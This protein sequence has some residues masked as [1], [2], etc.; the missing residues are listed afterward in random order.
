MN[1]KGINSSSLI[2]LIKTRT[3]DL[4]GWN[5]YTHREPC[6]LGGSSNPL[7]FDRTQREEPY[8]YRSSVPGDKLY[9]PLPSSREKPL[10]FCMRFWTHTDTHTRTHTP[11]CLTIWAMNDSQ[12]FRINYSYKPKT[13]HFANCPGR[14]GEEGKE[15]DWRKRNLSQSD[16]WQY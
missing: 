12:S 8:A 4:E 2:S 1:L 13:K 7:T 16:N 14:R 11:C 3:H 6:C 10:T 15:T 5:A 9:Q